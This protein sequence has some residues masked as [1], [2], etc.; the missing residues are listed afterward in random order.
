MRYEPLSEEAFREYMSQAGIPESFLEL[1]TNLYGA[2]RAG[3]TAETTDTFERV[4]GRAPISLK[5]FAQDYKEV[6]Q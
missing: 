2:A 4:V 6:W 5:K 1:M 3:Y